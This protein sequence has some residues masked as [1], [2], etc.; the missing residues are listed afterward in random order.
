Q[1]RTGRLGGEPLG[2]VAGSDEQ[3]GRGVDA[4]AVQAE[5]LGGR[6]FD[7]LGQKVLQVLLFGVQG[8]HAPA[9]QAQG[10]LGGK[11]HLVAPVAGQQ[12]RRRGRQVLSG[13]AGQA[14][15][16]LVGGGEAE[17]AD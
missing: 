10:G 8:E 13:D 16:Q 2:V 11:G 17:V 3:G 7:Q 5:Q 12:G 1:G 14:L 15:S 4:H 6:L 9:Q